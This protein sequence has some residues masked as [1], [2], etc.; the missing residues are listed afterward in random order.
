MDQQCCIRADAIGGAG[1]GRCLVTAF[2]GREAP[3]WSKFHPL[4]KLMR[5]LTWC[6][7][8]WQ[9]LQPIWSG[10]GKV[11]VV[12]P[13]W[14]VLG[15]QGPWI[16]IW[17]LLCMARCPIQASQTLLIRVKSKLSFRWS[18][19]I[20]GRPINL[21]V[22]NLESLLLIPKP[23]EWINPL[24]KLS[25]MDCK[26]VHI[27]CW[28]CMDLM[29]RGVP[30]Q[31]LES[32]Y[33][34]IPVWYTGLG[35]EGF[36]LQRVLTGPAALQQKRSHLKATGISSCSF[37]PYYRRWVYPWKDLGGTSGWF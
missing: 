10:A 6:F 18:A 8:V 36:S 30:Y 7:G 13:S 14:S 27:S 32:L 3:S 9:S 12:K 17:E 21:T 29:R 24:L 19:G 37:S 34:P 1:A 25:S 31:K 35:H 20:K 33:M 26:T 23:A 5:M 2:L 15:Q 16:N 4:R 11:L 22:F 28:Y